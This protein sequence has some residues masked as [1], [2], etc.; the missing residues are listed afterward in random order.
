ME[1]SWYTELLNLLGEGRNQ[2]KEVDRNPKEMNKS[3]GN[4]DG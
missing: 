2:L 3:Q 4:S 1:I